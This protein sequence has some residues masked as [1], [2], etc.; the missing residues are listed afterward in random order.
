VRGTGKYAASVQDAAPLAGL[1]RRLAKAVREHPVAWDL[2]VRG[3]PGMTG[4][5]QAAGLLPT[6][7]FRGGAFEGA[8]RRPGMPTRRNCSRGGA[9]ATPAP[10]AAS[11]RS[12]C[13]W[14]RE[15]ATP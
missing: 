7:N 3:T 11:A 14:K 6:R 10:C 2:Q 9:V 12:R 4:G 1:G 13:S 8:D 5:L 15:A